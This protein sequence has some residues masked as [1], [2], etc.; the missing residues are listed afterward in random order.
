MFRLIQ[1]TVLSLLVVLLVAGCEYNKFDEIEALNEVEAVGSPFAQNLAYEYRA[2]SSRELNEMLDY[3]DALH[4]ARKGLAAAAGNPVLPEPLVD[5]NLLPEHMK[6]LG[7]ARARLITVFE[8]GAREVMPEA[9]AFAQVRFDCWIEEQEENW[10]AENISNCKSDFMNALSNLEANVVPPEVVVDAP[11]MTPVDEVID[12]SPPV[13]E[14]IEPSEPMA[15]EDAMY[16]VFFDWD[17]YKIGEGA[18]SVVEAVAEEIEARQGNY[19]VVKVVGHA[20]TSGSK[21]YNRKLSMKRAN[22]VR[23]SLV[24]MG[25]D[26]ALIKVEGRGQEELL[27]DTPDGVREPANRRVN[28]SFE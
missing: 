19:E 4:F 13:A 21:A 10:Q 25:V 11:E 1:R 9:S 26:P 15:P 16:L 27:V 24:E 23:D 28:I 5:W 14:I 6:E 3:P 12:M 18:L 20:D 17:S 2:F 22:S 8:A 7:E